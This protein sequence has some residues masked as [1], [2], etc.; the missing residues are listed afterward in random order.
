MIL[1]FYHKALM[2]RDKMGASPMRNA[3]AYNNVPALD[4]NYSACKQS[5]NYINTQGRSPIY[6]SG[7]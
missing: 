5:I 1:V 2:H 3:V 6:V 7:M 4:I